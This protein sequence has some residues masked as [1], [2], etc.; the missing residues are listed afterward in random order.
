MKACSAYVDEIQQLF[1][2]NSVQKVQRISEGP[3]LNKNLDAYCI[4][5]NMCAF[6]VCTSVFWNRLRFCVLVIVL[7]Y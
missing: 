4:Q 3:E 5:N 1:P 6:F 2:E 7:S